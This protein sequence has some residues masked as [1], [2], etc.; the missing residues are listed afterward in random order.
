MTDSFEGESYGE[1]LAI[2]ES[3]A[4]AALR[5]LETKKSPGI[6]GIPRALIYATETESIKILVKICKQI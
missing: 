1:E 6:D 5:A 2:V 3:E 4:K